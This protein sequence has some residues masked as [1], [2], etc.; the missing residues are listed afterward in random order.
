MKRSTAIYYITAIELNGTTR[1]PKILKFPR[2]LQDE[3]LFNFRSSDTDG[4]DRGFVLGSLSTAVPKWNPPWRFITLIS[5]GV[6]PEASPAL[7]S[8]VMRQANRTAASRVIMV[9]P[10]QRGLLVGLLNQLRFWSQSRARLDA[11]FVEC[12][13]QPT[14]ILEMGQFRAI[15]I[16]ITRENLMQ[17]WCG[18]IEPENWPGKP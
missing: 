17:K 1:P 4:G 7:L 2:A 11:L 12:K 15:A 3:V 18:T 16:E 9:L 8:K 5:D 14:Q 6:S 13:A 10:Q